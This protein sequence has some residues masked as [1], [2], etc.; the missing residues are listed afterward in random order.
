LTAELSGD[1][2]ELRWKPIDTT[3][4]SEHANGEVR[5][6]V[7]VRLHRFEIVARRAAASGSRETPPPMA[8]S[9]GID[10]DTEDG[11]R[12]GHALDK[13]IEVGKTYRYLAQQVIQ[14]RVGDRTLEM[15]GQYSQSAV[16]DTAGDAR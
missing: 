1:G 16:I 14:I 12:T 5:T 6:K 7:I 15:A 2:V 9:V 8:T 11:A 3:D 13:Q 10:L 4:S